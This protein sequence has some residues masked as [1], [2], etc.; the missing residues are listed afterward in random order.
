MIEI[1]RDGWKR[2]LAAPAIAAGVFAMTFVLALPLAM[3]V[4]GSIRTHLGASLA[5]NQAADG[6]NWDWW[7][8]FTADATGLGTTFTPSVIGFA[9][10][11]DNVSSVLD[12]RAEIP[13]IAWALAIYLTGWAFVTGGIIDRYAR[14]RATRTY[15]IPH[16]LE[17]GCLANR[18]PYGLRMASIC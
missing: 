2:V 9:A 5:A 4:R 11:L 7:Q 3:A 17:N 13:P 6:V 14:Q 1:W 8:E 18:A 16:A 10:V 12:G 15:D